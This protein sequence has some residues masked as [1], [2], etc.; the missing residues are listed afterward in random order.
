MVERTDGSRGPKPNNFF[1]K[2]W[3]GAAF[4]M[5]L[6]VALVFAALF[7]YLHHQLEALEKFPRCS[8][9]GCSRG[10]TR[11]RRFLLPEVD[12]CQ[13]FFRFA[14]GGVT[15]RT[16]EEMGDAELDDLTGL[17]KVAVAAMRRAFK[18]LRLK[19]LAGG[20]GSD[21]KTRDGGRN[22]TSVKTKMKATEKLRGLLLADAHVQTLMEADQTSRSLPQRFPSF[23]NVQQ[24]KK[25][26]SAQ[27]TERARAMHE[28]RHVVKGLGLQASPKNVSER[29]ASHV[30]VA[31]TWDLRRALEAC[32]FRF[33][34]TSLFSFQPRP[35]FLG[36]P[37]RMRLF[38]KPD[39]L[40]FLSERLYSGADNRTDSFIPDLLKRLALDSESVKMVWD[41]IPEFRGKYSR[42]QF[43]E[44]V[45]KFEKELAAITPRFEGFLSQFEKVKKLSVG[46][47]SKLCPSID[48][49]SLFRNYNL[50]EA[51]LNNDT[52]VL[53]HSP[54]YFR[55]LDLLLRST[56]SVH[57]QFYILWQI[58]WQSMQYLPDPAR[59]LRS[60]LQLISKPYGIHAAAGFENGNHDVDAIIKHQLKQFAKSRIS[61][62]LRRNKRTSPGEE[63]L[64]ADWP[65]SQPIGGRRS[66]GDDF[67][68]TWPIIKL[69]DIAWGS[70]FAKT[71]SD[72]TAKP[73]VRALAKEIQ[74]Q[75]EA[76]V[77]AVRWMDAATREKA[78]TKVKSIVWH[79]GD[80]DIDADRYYDRLQ[81]DQRSLFRSFLNWMSFS[82]REEASLLVK[83]VD[84]DAWTYIKDAST[85]NAFYTSFEN[86]VTVP[87]GI[88]LDPFFNSD[89]PKYMQYGMLGSVIAHEA[90][91]A[92]DP[93]NTRFGEFGQFE[94]W[95][96]KEAAKGFEER[97]QCFRESFN[98]TCSQFDF[99]C[100]SKIT[101]NENIADLG[102]LVMAYEAYKSWSRG[103]GGDTNKRLEPSTFEG[104]E[105]SLN[106]DQAFF[107]SFAQRMCDPRPMDV[108]RE[109]WAKTRDSHSPDPIRVLGTLRNVQSFQEAFRCPNEAK[110][111]SQDK[112][113]LWW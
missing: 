25:L 69:M 70:E 95:W 19:I 39:G 6:V 61:P 43:A 109:K 13:D 11:M 110:M 32:H 85:P 38:L 20:E 18:E 105:V 80:P 5:L 28:L 100:H 74:D 33:G 44:A 9:L 88:L 2:L 76:R 41:T 26:M 36:A 55:S 104:D 67:T 99:R 49:I 3:L 45:W 52:L 31:A 8:T 66:N 34:A 108:I 10:L 12:P 98:E 48:W 27:R 90:A 75:L 1:L 16:V 60:V 106:N 102:G 54:E 14:C 83:R 4:L 82:R 30:N 94:N 112:C 63:S 59:G 58:A 81:V 77:A 17:N 7:F 46:R 47:L 91:H 51:E 73:S 71:F 79:V 56:P 93:D 29:S 86:S 96:S 87:A 78:R 113:F 111:N 107:V 15:R 72:A 89:Y 101:L 23:A 53:V 37:H 21:H 40:S 64:A 92:L 62:L 24:L 68:S 65:H 50:R 42:R 97:V 35:D 103:R 57:L 22:A 84:R